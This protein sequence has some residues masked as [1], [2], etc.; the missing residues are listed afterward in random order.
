MKFEETNHPYYCEAFE[1]KNLNEYQSW[2]DFNTAWGIDTLDKDYNM[3]FRYDIEQHFNN[4]DKA[5][6]YMLKLFFIQQRHGKYV[7]IVVYNIKE[8]DIP[9]IEKWLYENWEY[10]KT[11]WK[12]FS[13]LNK[14][15]NE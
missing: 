9:I 10:M 8:N 2:N 1:T 12:E 14:N 11:M 6:G 5:D 4:E 15:L 3:L 13:Q 7:P